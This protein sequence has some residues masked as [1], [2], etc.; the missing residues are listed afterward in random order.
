[1]SGS[2][3]ARVAPEAS[4]IGEMSSRSR[5]S[6]KHTLCICPPSTR[7]R[8]QVRRVTHTHTTHPPCTDKAFRQTLSKTKGCIKTDAHTV[9]P[10]LRAAWD[11]GTARAVPLPTHGLP[12]VWNFGTRPGPSEVRRAHSCHHAAGGAV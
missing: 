2:P 4:G 12:R 7:D 9:H 3:E 6:S 1:M 11:T 8:P 10:V 5:Q